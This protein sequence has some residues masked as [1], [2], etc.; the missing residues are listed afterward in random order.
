MESKICTSIAT[1]KINFFPWFNILKI[2][3]KIVEK[4][5]VVK[6]EV[7]K[8]FSTGLGADK[9]KK[10]N[11]CLPTDIEII[12]YSLKKIKPFFHSFFIR[13]GEKPFF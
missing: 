4:R 3:Y 10:I 2:L 11:T 6:S 9:N 1:K 13:G 7:T 12:S 8:S 5:N